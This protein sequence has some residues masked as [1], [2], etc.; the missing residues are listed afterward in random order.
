M[1]KRCFLI[2]FAELFLGVYAFSATS[3]IKLSGRK[4]RVLSYQMREIVLDV[5]EIYL[6]QG[7]ED[8]VVSTEGIKNPY[9]FKEAVT[10]AAA[11]SAVASTEP[12]AVVVAPVVYDDASSLKVIGANFAKQMRGTLARGSTHYLQLQ[13]GGMLKSGTSFPVTSRGQS[14][15]LTISDVNSRG[16]TLK[17][18]DASLTVPFDVSSGGVAGATKDSAN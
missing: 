10:A 11:P 5:A 17:V 14:Y 7:D 4:D 1:K 18:G 16:Y 13:G 6:N 8:F 2:L 15:T 12:D 3:E 9:V